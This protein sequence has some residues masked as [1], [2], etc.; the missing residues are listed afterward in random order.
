M[1]H[2]I[3]AS[4]IRAQVCMDLVLFNAAILIVSNSGPAFAQSK[5]LRIVAF[6]DSLTAGF[7]LQPPEAFP[8]KLGQALKE[9]GYDVEVINA[10]VSGDTTA[11][12]LER[13][14]WAIP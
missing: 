6:G 5:P 10:G 13:L 7:G 9:K 14:D 11:A 8:L 4:I 2:G 12:G 3:G 1:K